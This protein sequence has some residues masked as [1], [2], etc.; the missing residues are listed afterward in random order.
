MSEIWT[1]TSKKDGLVQ[2]TVKNE[3]TGV[4][5]QEERT[6]TGVTLMLVFGG[7]LLGVGAMMSMQPYPWRFR[8]GGDNIYLAGPSIGIEAYHPIEEALE[9]TKN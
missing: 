9:S 8:K 5:R 7:Y 6:P 1:A 3:E 4:E 2:F